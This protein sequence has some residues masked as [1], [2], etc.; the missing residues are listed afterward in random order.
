MNDTI[1]YIL[2]RK[3]LPSMNAGKAMA[4]ASHAANA[5]VSQQTT[6]RR[7]DALIERVQQWQKS[8]PQGFGTVL[9]LAVTK[10]EMTKA[11]VDSIATKRVPAEGITDPTY[12][13]RAS[14]EL[15]NLIPTSLDT[16]PRQVSG[17]QVNLWR[18]EMTCAYVFGTKEELKDILGH[19][20]LHP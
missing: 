1:L 15:A 20:P 19:L 9:V 16:L 2:M 7:S 11:I 13:Y 17:D 10:D 18:S 5:F 3:D 8:T 6:I 14:L 12:P 4:Q